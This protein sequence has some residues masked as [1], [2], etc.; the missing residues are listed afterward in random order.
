MAIAYWVEKIIY[1]S[2]GLVATVFFLTIFKVWGSEQQSYFFFIG[3]YQSLI[4]VIAVTMIVGFI[5]E[6]LWKW[7]VHSIFKPR[8][9][10]R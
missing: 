2:V 1:L 3:D 4:V 8:Q 5:L 6:K 10:R 9:R 7:E